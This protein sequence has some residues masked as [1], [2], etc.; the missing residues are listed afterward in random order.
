MYAAFALCSHEDLA[1]SCARFS[2]RAHIDIIFSRSAGCSFKWRHFI[3]LLPRLRLRRRPCHVFL[4]TPGERDG[5][6]RPVRPPP[7]NQ[8]DRV[9]GR[10]VHTA[11][12]Y[13]RAVCTAVSLFSYILVSY[14]LVSQGTEQ[15]HCARGGGGTGPSTQ[16]DAGRGGAVAAALSGTRVVAAAGRR[17]GRPGWR[18]SAS[19]RSSATPAPRC[20][21]R[22]ALLLSP[23]APVS[24]LLSARPAF[25]LPFLRCGQGQAANTHTYT[26]THTPTHMYT[27]THTRTHTRTHTAPRCASRRAL[28]LSPYAPMSALPTSC[29]SFPPS[30]PAPRCGSR[31]GSNPTHVHTCALHTRT[32]AR[33]HTHAYTQRLAARQGVA[34]IAGKKSIVHAANMDYRPT[35]WP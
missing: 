10:L 6:P 21:S 24:A 17:S 1:S 30:L 29:R 27:K 3:I 14:T 7:R 20:A 15:G 9:H 25:S 19:S 26:H 32:H 33:T 4:R 2:L 12:T 11:E 31:Q 16:R 22:R 35:R 18:R 8:G 13:I 23:C 34:P 5:R 28:L